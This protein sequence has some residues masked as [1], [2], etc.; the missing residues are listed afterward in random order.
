MRTPERNL[1]VR[2]A[3]LVYLSSIAEPSV[4]PSVAKVGKRGINAIRGESG[5]FQKVPGPKTRTAQ[6]STPAPST[7]S[8]KRRKK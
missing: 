8:V 2:H 7:R 4:G 6:A 1:Q 5:K 3:V